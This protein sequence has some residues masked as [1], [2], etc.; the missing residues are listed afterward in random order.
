M[1]SIKEERLIEQ[2]PA[3]A[4]FSQ[5]Q[6]EIIIAITRIEGGIKP[7]APD[8]IRLDECAHVNIVAEF[9]LPQV[10]GREMSKPM[11]IPHMTVLGIDEY[12]AGI[13]DGLQKTYSFGETF[14]MKAVVG[15]QV[16]EIVSLNVLQTGLSGCVDPPVNGFDIFDLFPKRCGYLRG[17]VR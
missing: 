6:E 11:G 2:H 10:V 13:D 12:T 7:E 17:V 16:Q 8:D 14:R 15:V 5:C 3:I 1:N 4:M 9:Q